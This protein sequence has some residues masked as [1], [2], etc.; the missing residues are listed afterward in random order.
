[1]APQTVATIGAHLDAWEH[2]DHDD[3]SGV[4]AHH[5]VVPPSAPEEA[6]AS[7]LANADNGHAVQHGGWLEHLPLMDD[8]IPEHEWL[9]PVP[10]VAKVPRELEAAILDIFELLW[11]AIAKAAQAGDIVAQL[12]AERLWHVIP[13]MLL[14]QPQRPRERSEEVQRVAIQA[15]EVQ[16]IQARLQLFFSGE[17]RRLLKMAEAL[18][19]LHREHKAAQALPTCDGDAG[20]RRADAVISKCANTGTSAALQLLM[21]PGVAPCNARTVERVR[22]AVSRHRGRP[23]PPRTWITN[24]IGQAVAPGADSFKRTVKRGKRGGAQDFGRVEVRV[25]PARASPH[26]CPGCIIQSHLAI[27]H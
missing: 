17:W 18:W 10:T 27:G 6:S 24:H 16:A 13:K 9:H 25:Y 8:V 5:A 2:R 14:A 11:A 4:A 7:Q 26:Q 12:R 23:L 3:E 15:G 1:M 22:E 21:S 19:P 20:R